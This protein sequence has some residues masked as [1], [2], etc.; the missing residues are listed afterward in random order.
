MK[1]H[2][3]TQKPW[4]CT[5]T[6]TPWDREMFNNGTADSWQKKRTQNIM[7]FSS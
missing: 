2:Y 6:M 5:S 1:D 4:F 7:K 3:N